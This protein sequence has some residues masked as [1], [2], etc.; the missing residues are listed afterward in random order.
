[1]MFPTRPS[2][3]GPRML[4][5]AVLALLLA[6]CLALA[7][8]AEKPSGA[9]KRA[10]EEFLDAVA[11]GSPQA[12]AYAIHPADLEALRTRI[13]T[14]LREEAGRGDG[15]IRQRLFGPGR[16]LAELERLTPPDFYAA[17]GRKLYLFGREYKDAS[18]IAALPDKDGVVQIVLK[19]KGDKEHAKVDVVNVVSVRPYGKDWKAT[20]PSEIEAQI[21]DLMHARR[22][23]YASLPPPVAGPA[24]IRP[25]TASAETGLPPQIGELLDNASKAL[26]VPICEDYYQKYMSPNFRKMTSKKALEALIQNCKNSIGTREMLVAA[27]RIVKEL[28]PTF[29]YEGRRAV[30]DVSGQGLPF[31]RFVLEQVDKKWY[32]AE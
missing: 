13:L 3:A 7:A 24:A 9:Q 20:L 14:Q 5:L 22:S 19:G 8:G 23:I 18:Y 12:V 29:E 25:G 28:V 6:P 1:M 30:Y 21:D 4:L 10:A 16:S 27:V 15:T 32:I 11:S 2:S 26:A 31:D 17:I